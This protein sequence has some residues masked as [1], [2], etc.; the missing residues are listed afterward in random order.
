LAVEEYVGGGRM[1]KPRLVIIGSPNRQKKDRPLVE[2]AEKEFQV[3]Y[4]P[5]TQARLGLARSMTLMYDG[6]SVSKSDRVLLIPTITHKEM[7][8][9]IARMLGDR[10]MPFNHKQYLLTLNEDVMF[11]YLER[12]GIPTRESIFICASSSLPAGLKKIRFPATVRMGAK[13]VKVTD[14]ETLKDVVGLAGRGTPVEIETP[15]PT[16]KTIWTFVVGEEV[17][18]GYEKSK[19]D[20][21]STSVDDE[22]KRLA[23][24]VRSALGCDYCALK[25]IAD[26]RGKTILDKITFCPDF[27][28]FQKITSKNV[29]SYIVGHLKRRLEEEK[30]EWWVP[31]PILDVMKKFPRSERRRSKRLR[32]RGRSSR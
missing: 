5:I 2:E 10:C 26:K 31:K 19:N 12:F 29:A 20:V 22:I 7:F 24:S 17:V 8:Y 11:K 3:E 1:A 16:E 27:G 13:R 21:K 14:A 6:K 9:T 28:N 23:V 18:A 4:V 15:V 32:R 30:V 25:F